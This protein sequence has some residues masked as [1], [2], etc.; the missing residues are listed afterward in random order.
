M[1]ISRD[2]DAMRSLVEVEHHAPPAFACATVPQVVVALWRR[3]PTRETILRAQEVIT[4]LAARVG[5]PWAYLA[6]IEPTSPPPP[7]GVI[8]EIEA[9]LSAHHELTAAVGVFEGRPPWLTTGL[10]LA[11][12]IA[13]PPA[14]RRV[15]RGKVC[16]D[17]D[18]AIAWLAH[19]FDPG[20]CAQ[21]R[22]LVAD[23]R[24]SLP[25]E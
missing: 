14:V 3:Q 7:L 21:I 8:A 23:L 4:R 11:L 5:S 1:A 12:S 15:R 22:P 13:T 24:A 18:E 17:L 20:A 25:P 16:V 2:A 10:D 9:Y 6:I 19:R